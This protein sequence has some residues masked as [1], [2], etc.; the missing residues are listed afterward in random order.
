MCTIYVRFS[1][2]E[3]HDNVLNHESIV[4]FKIEVQKSSSKKTVCTD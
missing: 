2:S 3:F 4:W 1:V